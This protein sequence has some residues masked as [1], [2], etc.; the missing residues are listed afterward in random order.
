[1]EQENQ[2]HEVHCSCGQANCDAGRHRTELKNRKLFYETN[3]ESL[4]QMLLKTNEELGSLRAENST[5]RNAQKACETCDAP[6]LA[7]TKALRAEVAALQK[8]LAE[9]RANT[10]ELRTAL[11][12]AKGQSPMVTG[13]YLLG[14]QSIS[15][16][17]RALKAEA[18]VERLTP[19]WERLS[20]DVV[21]QAAT[22]LDAR[23]HVEALLR[24]LARAS[25]PVS[26]EEDAARKWWKE[27]R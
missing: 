11:A 25:A 8:A 7:E 4:R 27:T 5:L 12:I 22:I 18:E 23:Q 3:E 24:K 10:D 6:T 21:A 2:G 17:D 20:R 14:G 1:M 26:E 19:E 15:W 13:N 16:R 9:E